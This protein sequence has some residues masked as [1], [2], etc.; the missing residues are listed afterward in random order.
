MKNKTS[1]ISLVIVFVL[2]AGIVPGVFAQGTPGRLPGPIGEPIGGQYKNVSG[3]V[4]ILIRVVEWFYTILFIVAVLFI[5]L[6]AYNFITSKGDQE[7]VGT[8]RKQ[9]LYAVIGIAV[10]LVSYAII[11]LVQNTLVQGL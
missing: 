7:K 6:A 5:L 11:S 1:I 4:G 3:L 2:L 9:L 8:A 10:G